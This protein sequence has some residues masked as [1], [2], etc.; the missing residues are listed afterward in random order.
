MSHVSSIKG[1]AI[2]LAQGWGKPGWKTLSE[3]AKTAASLGYKGMQ[4]PLWTGSG[5][6]VEKAAGSQSY[7]EDL[8]AEVTAAGCPIVELAN[9]C[10]T[11]L[12]RCAP[13]YLELHQWPVPPA[14]H[15]N[16]T[17]IQ[18]W[19][20]IR[21]RQSILAAKNFG[22]NRVAAFS[23]T[24]MFHLMY[25][26]P[27]RPAGLVEAGFNALA[28]AWRPI[29]DFGGEH[30]VDVC[31]E[32]HPG[33]DLMDGNTF[34]QFLGYV[35]NHPKCNILLDLSHSVL[36]GM[37]L[38]QMLGF[39]VANKERIKMFHVKDAEFNPTEGGG[40]YDG[41]RSW[42]DRAGR[43]RSLGDGQIDY[44]AVIAMLDHL[45]LDLWAVLEWECC[46]K[47]WNQGVE[48]GA[49]F[50]EAWI[51]GTT[52]PTKADVIPHNE[53]AFDDFAAGKIDKG[54]ISR[55]IGVKESEVNTKVAS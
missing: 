34:N 54:V 45:G 9:H 7:C 30:G 44:S 6:D 53:G 5:I 52:P 48:E 8:Q 51:N 32:L 11:Q 12:V 19:A 33:E 13:V 41:Y 31:F 14:L 42:K 22:F 17:A 15:G 37:G 39:I 36:S 28:D 2:F 4:A 3:C 20:R 47:G 18:E 26:W 55:L 38:R 10:E 43:F 1:P 29:F 23:G 16:H 25:P 21:A 35:D 24:G 46:F 40:V 49:K 27:Q 50:I